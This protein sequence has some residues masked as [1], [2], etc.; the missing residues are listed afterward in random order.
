MRRDEFF[1]PLLAVSDASPPPLP[2]LAWW[3]RSIGFDWY[4][5]QLTLPL[6]LADPRIIL[7]NNYPAGWTSP[8]A[9]A[10]GPCQEVSIVTHA[11]NGCVGMLS[12]ARAGE[13][14]GTAEL[15]AVMPHMTAMAQGVVA[16]ESHAAMAR[17]FPES[18]IA[19]NAREK[20]VLRWTADGKTSSEIGQLLNLSTA[21]VN[22]HINKTL[23]KLNAINKTQAVVK[24]I[25]LGL[26]DR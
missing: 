6:P 4:A 11:R 5:L 21:T 9:A 2:G 24:A 16:A 23:A 22:F 8:G 3:A 25:V 10:R 17:H 19:L 20:E 7:D 26:L 12:L 18:L 13:P 15:D 14:L 1:H